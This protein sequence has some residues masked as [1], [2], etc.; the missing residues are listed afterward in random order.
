MQKYDAIVIGCGGMG[1]AVLYTLASRG[2]R[3]LGVDQYQ[4]PHS[5]GSSH[6]QSRIIRQAYFEHPD[7]VPLLLQ[8]YRDW[9]ELESQTGETL[10]HQVGLL[11]VGPTDG[12]LVPGVL[13]SAEAHQLPIERFSGREI[14]QHFP[15]FEAVDDCVGLFEQRAGYLF[16]EKSIRTYLDQARRVGASIRIDPQPSRWQIDGE[17]VRVESGGETFFA[18]RLVLAVG[19]WTDQLIGQI[20]VKLQVVRKHMYWFANESPRYREGSPVF[21]FETPQGY[22]Y[23]F[24]QLDPRGIKV[25]DHRGGEQVGDPNDLDNTID[26]KDQRR[27]QRFLRNHLPDISER[28]TDHQVCMYTRSPDEHFIMDRHP[29]ASQVFFVA[30]LSGHGYKFAPVIGRAIADMV[31]DGESALPVDFFALKR[32]A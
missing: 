8:A 14:A 7:Y 5:C 2:L 20:G 4:V 25:A 24:P 15:G 17:G 11:Q 23:G 30:G 18:D 26:K 16:V 3:V 31:V 6:G 9:A 29:D 12:F 21:F 19:S 22:F 27:T 10:L 32:F 13:A 28:V 1:S